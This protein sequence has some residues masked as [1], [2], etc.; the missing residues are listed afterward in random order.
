MFG[1][2]HEGDGGQDF[3]YGDLLAAIG[4]RHATNRIGQHRIADELALA[5]LDA[6][7][8]ALVPVDQMRRGVDVDAQARGLKQR[9]RKGGDGA[10]AVG[11]GHVNDRRQAV[12]RIAERGQ[13]PCY[14]VQRQVEAFRM[15]GKE[16]FDLIARFAGFHRCHLSP[17]PDKLDCQTSPV[18][19]R[20]FILVLHNCGKTGSRFSR[21]SL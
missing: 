17:R 11:P 21:N 1:K 12:L 20:C 4:L 3:K 18:W 15:Q 19:R 7:P 9:P 5:A 14:P 8:V 10:L 16:F 6:E 2:K 13:E